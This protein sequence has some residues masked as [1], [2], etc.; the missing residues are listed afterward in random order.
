MK[1]ISL[2]G[3]ADT[4]D[5]LLQQWGLLENIQVLKYPFFLVLMSGV[6]LFSGVNLCSSVNLLSGA[7]FLLMMTP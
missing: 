5:Q 7:F 4:G 6:N 3:M 1:T 2:L